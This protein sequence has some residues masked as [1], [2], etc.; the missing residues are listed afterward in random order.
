LRTGCCERYLGHKWERTR[1]YFG[2]LYNDELH[3]VSSGR[4]PGVEKYVR[5]SVLVR[6]PKGKRLLGEYR[7]Y[8][9]VPEGCIQSR[10]EKS[11]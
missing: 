11:L 4:L 1:R 6:Q 7:R 10:V 8:Y 3:D 2:K 5:Y 9:C